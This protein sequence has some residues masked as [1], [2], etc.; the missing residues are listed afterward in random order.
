MRVGVHILTGGEMP[1]PDTI[2]DRDYLPAA[3]AASQY[4][5]WRHLGKPEGADSGG[6][7][8]R[9]WQFHAAI[10]GRHQMGLQSVKDGIAVPDATDQMLAGSW[11]LGVILQ[12][13]QQV[14]SE[15]VSQQLQ[16]ICVC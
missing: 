9:D 7:C 6:V 16:P 5:T 13:T 2:G 11:F 1:L 15:Q 12:H 10:S 4:A 3:G 14:L 8:Q